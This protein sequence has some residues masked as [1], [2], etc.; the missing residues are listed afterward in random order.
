MDSR[1]YFW[2]G[3][4]AEI[5][6]VRPTEYHAYDGAVT[7]EDRVDAVAR[8]LVAA[9]AAAA[10]GSGSGVGVAS[11]HALYLEEPDGQGH[12]HGPHSEHVNAAV[13]RV[14]AALGRLREKTG[15]AAW[16]ATN[17]VIVA[18]HGGVP[19]GRLSDPG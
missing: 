5:R 18:D 11:F 8:W 9:A 13:R 2:P 15:E 1:V 19:S 3:S 7:Y 14:D 12:A 4:E 6:G 16:N 10:A 17:V